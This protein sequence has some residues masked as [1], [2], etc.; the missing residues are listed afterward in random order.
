MSSETY[1][2]SE[3]GQ[4]VPVY[5]TQPEKPGLYLALFHG[6]RRPD[7]EMDDWGFNGPLLGPLEWVHTTY[8]LNIRVKFARKVDEAAYFSKPE[9]PDAHD[10]IMADDMIV[11]ANRYYGDWSSF[12]VCEDETRKPQDTFRSK[13]RRDV[14]YRVDIK[15]P[16]RL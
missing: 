14:Q 13:V 12:Y 9:Y 4:E 2:Q 5:G 10:L 6:R 7:E 3:S 1:I 16:P 15:Q 11:Y 8:A